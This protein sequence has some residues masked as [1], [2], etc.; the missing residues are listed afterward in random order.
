MLQRLNKQIL[1]FILRR[2]KKDVL[3][4]LP[5]KIETLTFAQMEETQRKL[6]TAELMKLNSEFRNEIKE[7]GYEKSQI[8]ILSM[9]T[10]L[11][12]ICCDPNLCYEENVSTYKARC[13]GKKINGRN[14]FCLRK[15][16]FTYSCNENNKSH[17]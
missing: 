4:E 2:L 17:S 5:D 9:L 15:I 16:K 13:Y 8:K 14:Y 7:N 6:Y 1:P 12:Q 10:R 3:K 11:R